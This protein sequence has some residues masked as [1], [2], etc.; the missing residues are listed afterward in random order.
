M[1]AD[2]PRYIHEF[3]ANTGCRL[4]DLLRVKGRQS[5][6]ES[7][8]ER[9]KERERERERERNLGILDLKEINHFIKFLRVLLFIDSTVYMNTVYL[10]NIITLC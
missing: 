7:E 3:C 5:R 1:L 6:R 9:E 2:Q 4:N 10:F 8:K